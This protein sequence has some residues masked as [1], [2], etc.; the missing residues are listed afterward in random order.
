MKWTPEGLTALTRLEQLMTTSPCV[1]LPDQSK[2][3]NCFVCEK[4][5]FMSSVLTQD[6]GGKQRPV[7]YY[8][9]QLDS[10]ARGLVCCLRA[11][12]AATAAVMACADIVVMCELTVH[13]PHAVHDLISQA[14]TAHLTPAPL[15]E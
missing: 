3:F 10:V 8:S 14:K 15:S 9:K 5:C 2:P 11:V 13:V 1:G 4:N 7:G 12:A 6:H